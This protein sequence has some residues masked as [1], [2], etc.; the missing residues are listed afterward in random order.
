MS[1]KVE[2]TEA[3]TQSQENTVECQ[4]KPGEVWEEGCCTSR[5][6]QPAEELIDVKASETDNSKNELSITEKT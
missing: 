4:H 5:K 1:S 3:P 2:M 6:N